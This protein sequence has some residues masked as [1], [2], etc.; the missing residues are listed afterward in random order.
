[1]R[2]R[3]I[4]RIHVANARVHEVPGVGHAAPVT[5]PEALA[6]SVREFFFRVNSERG[7]CTGPLSVHPAA[8]R[9]RCTEVAVAVIPR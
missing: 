8:W 5:H 7:C 4:I 2:I 9:A 1:M 3:S 6:K